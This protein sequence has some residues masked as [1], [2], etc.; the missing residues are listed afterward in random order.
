MITT[1]QFIQ[2]M[3]CVTFNT[4]LISIFNSFPSQHFNS[5]DLYVLHLKLNIDNHRLLPIIYH[6]LVSEYEIPEPKTVT[7]IV[8]L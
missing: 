7:I 2:T 8:G 5:T 1:I 3:N 6:M 4:N